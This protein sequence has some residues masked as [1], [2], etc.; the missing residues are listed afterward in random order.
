MAAIDLVTVNDNIYSWGSTTFKVDGK[1]MSGIVG[2]KFSD[3]RERVMAY[4]SS[5]SHAPRGRT[6]GKY[7]AEGSITVHTDTG[8]ALRK[9]CASKKGGSSY[10]NYEFQFSIQ[11]QE[12]DLSLVNI[13]LKRCCIV[14][15]DST[16]EE[17]PDPQTEE[18]PL[19][20]MHITRNGLTLYDSTGGGSGILGAITGALNEIF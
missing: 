13:E 10:G 4:G 14:G 12:R 9:Y 5:K 8:Q 20:I 3:K 19:S 6:R 11:L 16:I 15:T 18:I 2:A 7:S 1:I 17:N